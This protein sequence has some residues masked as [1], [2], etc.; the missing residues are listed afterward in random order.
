MVR[1]VKR[2]LATVVQTKQFLEA[3]IYI[4]QQ[5]QI[6]NLERISKYVQREH[7]MSYGDCKRLLDSVVEDGFIMEYLAVGFKGARTG[8]EQEG[9]KIPTSEEFDYTEM[10]DG[11]DWYCFTCHKPGD[12]LLCSEC[13]RTY[14]T[15]CT[16][17]DHSG[18]KFTCSIC[19]AGKKKN[20]MKKKMLNTLLSYTILRLREKTKELH[21][22]GTKAEEEDFDRFVYQRM[23]LSAME[24]K[25]QTSRYRCLEEFYA[26]AQTVHH[27]CMLLYGNVPGGITDLASIMLTDCKYDLDEIELCPNCYY[28]SNAKPEQW[29]CQPC[30]P[31]HDLVYAKLKGFG[32]WPAKV[33]NEV[34]GKMDVRFFGGWHQRAVIPAEYI[35]PVTTNLNS[36]TVKRTVGFTKACKELKVH[37]QLLEER[38]RELQDQD[39]NSK[40][41]FEEEE[42]EEDKKE[43]KKEETRV[44]LEEEMEE[45]E[46]DVRRVTSTS[47][48]TKRKRKSASVKVASPDESFVVTSSEDKVTQPKALHVKTASKPTVTSSLHTQTQ[49]TKTHVVGTQTDKSDTQDDKDDD[50]ED[51]EPV[52]KMPRL[53]APS[54]V[55]E[56][57]WQG[58]LDK[59]TSDVSERL[60]KQS[61]EEKNKALKELTDRLKKDFEEDKQAAVARATT[62]VSREIEKARKAA[63]DK[64][65]EQYMEEMKK[66]AAK[67]KEAIS[68]TK[69]K[70]WCFNCEEEAMYHCCWNTSYCSVRC[71]QEHWH[72]EHKRVCRRKR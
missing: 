5:K 16:D 62:N 17:Q 56:A 54:E 24:S 34:E 41:G 32:Y 4:R 30:N 42:E 38:E 33:I 25:V 72:K 1:P 12:L 18:S 66:L 7:N 31:P 61:E 37:Q 60:K 44:P 52:K 55:S 10:R 47:V 6:P 63:E 9:Y 3:V 20:K 43:D 71:Q 48:D 67:H 15:N 57:E 46:V 23:D 8:L 29:F 22:I 51:D 13:F 28:M 49:R 58:R 69:K 59:A 70:Q 19:K 53:A 36:L 26:D 39:M 64:C 40:E 68:Q 14:H 27:N 2:R 50:D 65:K 21:K 45:E 35:R 11:H